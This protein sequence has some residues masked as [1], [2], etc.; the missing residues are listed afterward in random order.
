MAK[1]DITKAVAGVQSRINLLDS[2]VPATAR[3]Q[4]MINLFE[5]SERTGSTMYEYSDVESWKELVDSNGFFDSDNPVQRMATPI[6]R[7]NCFFV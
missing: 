6:T 7:K 1:L 3:T 5:F 2:D 4:D